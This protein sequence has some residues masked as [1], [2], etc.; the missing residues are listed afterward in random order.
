MTSP[1]QDGFDL[2]HYVRQ[3]WR[4]KWILLALIVLLPLATYLVTERQ[5]K[6]YEAT[7]LM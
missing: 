2:R 1:R 7:T 5:A 4:R 6:V 3:A